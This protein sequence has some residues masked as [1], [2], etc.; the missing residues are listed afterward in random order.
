MLGLSR[1]QLDDFIKIIMIRQRLIL[2]TSPVEMAEIINSVSAGYYFLFLDD[3]SIAS[4]Y[5][6]WAKLNDYSVQ[7]FKRFNLRPRY[8]HEWS[9]GDNVILLSVVSTPEYSF[10][11]SLIKILREFD[12][13]WYV[14][15]KG[16]FISRVK[17]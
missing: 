11:L 16:K 7:R 15:R 1:K 12:R 17:V 13:F 8:S 10:S 4:G 2:N 3:Y 5:I 6:I 9:E 14:N